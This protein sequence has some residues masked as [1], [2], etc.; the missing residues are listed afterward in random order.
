MLEAQLV[1][2]LF[3]MGM[4]NS[5]NIL[6]I[7]LGGTKSH[8]VPFL[9]LGQG[10]V[11]KGHQV[12]LVSAFPQDGDSPVEEVTPRKVEEAVIS[13]SK[14]DM[15]GPKLRGEMPFRLSDIFDYVYSVCDAFYTDPATQPLL[16][17]KVDLLILDGAFPECMLALVHYFRVPF[18]YLNTV[19]FYSYQFSLAGNPTMYSTTPFFDSYHTDR[20]TFLERSL[21]GVLHVLARG[22]VLFMNKF[23]MEPIVRKH[24]GTDIPSIDS[25]G[26][27]VSLILQNGHHSVT[28][29]R[30]FLPSVV[31]IA[32]IHCKEPKPLPKDLEEFVTGGNKKG[33][34]F[35]SF[36]TSV[37]SS[38]FPERLR[39]LMIEVFSKLPYQ[40][41]WKFVTDGDTMPDL[42]DNVR[43]A[44]W[45]P[46]QDLLGHPQLLAFVNHGGLHSIIEAVYHGVPMVTLPVFGDHSANSR[47][48][49]VD[50][51]SITLELRT[52]TADILLAAINKIIDDKRYKRNVEQR[53]LLLK[54]QPEPPLERALYWV[55]YVLRHRG[56]PHLQ[57][58]AKDLSFIQYFMLDTVAALLVTL[59]VLV[60]VIRIVW[61]KSYGRRKLD[62]LK[63]N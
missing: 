56:A 28:H 17:M 35:V 60:L 61:R 15:L 58:A 3:C 63:R 42:P 33:F 36:G 44:R 32:C 29:P 41:M 53:S 8:K 51:C 2:V 48:T 27:N 12:T 25:I 31:E 43:L 46:Q 6:M 24:F 47:K 20:M 37:H 49:E 23:Y 4:V 50:G 11:S 26:R 16:S 57:S 19:A 10:L 52:V 40:V 7:T 30:P 38:Q 22:V 1:T 9:A 18:I 39:L 14:L 34:V 54:D 13:Y 55:Q 21:N 45:L 62:K 5:A 59:Y